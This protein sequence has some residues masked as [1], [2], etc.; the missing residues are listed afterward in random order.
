[1]SSFPVTYSSNTVSCLLCC[2]SLCQMSPL[3]LLS[4]SVVSSSALLP[5]RCLLCCS[6]LFQLSP[7]LLLSLSDVS[8]AAPPS[9]CQMSH[10]LLLSLSYVS[11]AAPLFVSSLLCC[12]SSFQMSPLLFLPPPVR[13]LLC[14]CSPCRSLFCY[15]SPFQMSP[16]LFL[17]LSAV[18]TPAPLPVSCLLSS[19]S[20]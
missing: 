15:S 16:L 2:S 5:F 14:Y 17:S 4:L 9:P 18:S 8:S 3:L 11:T 6:S 19:L 20:P 12:S 7:L 10:L 1:M 13:C